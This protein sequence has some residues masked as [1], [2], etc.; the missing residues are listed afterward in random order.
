M[1]KKLFGGGAKSADQPEPAGDLVIARLNARA[2]PLDRGDL[3]EDPLDDVL[4]AK[5][6]GQVT[7]GGTQLTETGEIA[8]CDVEIVL[9]Q[10][11]DGALDEVRKCLEAQGA[12]KGSSL[13]IEDRE[14]EIAFGVNEGLA[15]YLNGTDLPDEVYADC[16]VNHIYSEFDRL[17]GAAGKVH[18]Y[19]NGPTETALYLYGPSHDAMVDSI[20]PFVE[21]YPLCQKARLEKIA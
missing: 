1:F 18:S 6:L 21:S 16:D 14:D 4:Q 3:Y 10:A 7:G 17:L 5:K 8:F 19:W 20:K 13:M 15:V 9:A 2:Q 12:P 11:S